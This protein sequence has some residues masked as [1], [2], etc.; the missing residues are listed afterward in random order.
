MIHLLESKGVRVFSL[1]E[2][3][4]KVNAFSLWRSEKPY[5]FLNTVKSAESS[6]FD[7]AHELGHLVLHQDGKATGRIAEEQANR[8]ASSFL[9]PSA[10]ILAEI[11]YVESLSQMIQKKLRWKVS[12]AALNYRL[13]KLE[14]T[15][16]WQ[17]RHFCIQIAR[18][19]FSKNEPNPIERETSVVWQKVLQSL[20]AER[21]TRREIAKALALPEAELDS[22]IFGILGNGAPRPDSTPKLSVV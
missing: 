5:M 10:D 6:R 3:S 15:S 8:F 22:L 9:M 14:L 4:L 13:R 1:A 20:W 21:V 16:E 19:G 11:P 17:N 7:A 12:L 18:E 2:N